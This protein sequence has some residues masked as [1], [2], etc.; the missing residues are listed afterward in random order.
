MRL[1]IYSEV[2]IVQVNGVMRNIA[3]TKYIISIMVFIAGLILFLLGYI[4]NYTFTISKNEEYN[5]DPFI[6]ADVLL[7][8]KWYRVNRIDSKIVNHDLLTSVTLNGVRIKLNGTF[9]QNVTL[10][11][12][13]AY[14]SCYYNG[15]STITKQE[16][17]NPINTKQFITPT[18][19]T[20]ASTIE[21]PPKLLNG[22]YV[23]NVFI[24]IQL[25][26]GTILEYGVPLVLSVNQQSNMPS[27]P[28][29]CNSTDSTSFNLTLTN[30]IKQTVLPSSSIYLVGLVL[31]AVSTIYILVESKVSGKRWLK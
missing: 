19:Y 10:I 7:N 16:I 8:N 12:L 31:V 18:F 2:W 30:T 14:I 13:D 26:N 23:V 22:V 21:N 28:S 15:T 20:V 4:Y 17:L 25:S 3:E 9:L 29:E 1:E 24:K 27:L 5:I 11:G 6:T